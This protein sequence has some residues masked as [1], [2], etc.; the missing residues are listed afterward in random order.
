MGWI[1]ISYIWIGSVIA[2]VIIV[3]VFMPEDGFSIEEIKEDRAMKLRRYI[4]APPAI[5]CLWPIVLFFIIYMPYHD[6]WWARK[7]AVK[8]MKKYIYESK[9]KKTLS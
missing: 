9:T 8:Q 6:K 3:K 7:Q 1:L 2:T 4:I 5:I